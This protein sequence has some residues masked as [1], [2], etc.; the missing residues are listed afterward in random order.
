M[1]TTRPVL[2]DLQQHWSTDFRERSSRKTVS[3]KE[4]IMCKDKYPSIFSRQTEAIE[5]IIL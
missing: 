4:Q 2:H 1:Y 3:F 5:F